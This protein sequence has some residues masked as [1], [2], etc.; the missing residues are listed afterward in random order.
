MTRRVLIAGTFGRGRGVAF[1]SDCG[2]H[3]APPGFCDWKGSAKLW[4]GIAE[5]AGVLR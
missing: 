5:W 2:P 4:T 1:T 3:R